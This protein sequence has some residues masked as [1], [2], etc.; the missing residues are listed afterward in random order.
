M[1]IFLHLFSSYYRWQLHWHFWYDYNFFQDI[2][3]IYTQNIWCKK[4]FV[5]NTWLDTW[6]MYLIHSVS[7][8]D[9]E[10]FEYMANN[11]TSI[12]RPHKISFHILYATS[13]RVPCF[14][15]TGWMPLPWII[16]SPA[17][18]TFS[19]FFLT[20]QRLHFSNESFLIVLI[21]SEKYVSLIFSTMH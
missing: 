7:N 6:Y 17:R 10:V 1:Y 9:K 18:N 19:S 8:T 16:S 15:Q 20:V 13:Q 11:F 2:N 5:S 21:F 12:F 3:K 4:H 14:C